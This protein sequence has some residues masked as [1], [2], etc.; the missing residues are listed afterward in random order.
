MLINKYI[1]KKFL[2]I[3]LQFNKTII[4]LNFKRKQQQ[5]LYHQ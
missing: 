5:Q 1:L 2:T 4:Y 3:S